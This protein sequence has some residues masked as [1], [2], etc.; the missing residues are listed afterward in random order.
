MHAETLQAL[1]F[2]L[3]AADIFK[4]M[5]ARVTARLYPGMGHTVNQDEIDAV[6]EIVEV[7]GTV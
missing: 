4:R 5:G 6:R 3:E 7:V 1:D 2:R